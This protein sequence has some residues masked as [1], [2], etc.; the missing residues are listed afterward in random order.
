MNKS[1]I[2][3]KDF[4][5]FKNCLLTKL[6]NTPQQLIN[7]NIIKQWSD[8][9]RSKKFIKKSCLISRINSLKK[10]D[11]NTIDSCRENF[12]LNK[13]NYSCLFL[14]IIALCIALIRCHT[15]I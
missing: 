4:R 15:F 12:K 13:E 6:K 1:T 7:E 10:P 5:K 3:P 8:D 2:T 9:C 11:P 14:I